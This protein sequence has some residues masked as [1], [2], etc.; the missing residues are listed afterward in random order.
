M[1]DD[2]NAGLEAAAKWLAKNGQCGLANLLLL[3]HGFYLIRWSNN[4]T[5]PLTY[6]VT[7]YASTAE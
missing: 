4:A 1:S 3:A 7:Y 2:Y 5:S 6:T